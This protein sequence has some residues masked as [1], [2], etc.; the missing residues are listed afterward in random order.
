[1]RRTQL[2]AVVAAAALAFCAAAGASPDD[3]LYDQYDNAGTVT[4]TSQDFESALD[5]FDSELADDFAVPAGPG[6]NVTGVEVQGVYDAVRGPRPRCTCACT[7]TAPGTCPAHCS[8]S[9][10][11]SPSPAARASS[12]R[13]IRR[14]A[15]SPG[16]TGS[17]SR[18]TRTSAPQVSGSGRTERFSRASVRPGRTRAA[19]MVS[20]PP[21]NG[22][23]RV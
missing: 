20:A 15:S 6:W 14:S 21:G 13:S 7:R 19:G 23:R 8:R 5:P 10:R 22:E 2:L 18:R 16:P 3:V 17:R 11:I 1:M 12:S 4:S 9:A